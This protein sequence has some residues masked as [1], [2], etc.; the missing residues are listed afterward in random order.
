M[1]GVCLRERE[2][3]FDDVG[4]GLCVVGREGVGK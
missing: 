1:S 3:L 2:M 4:V